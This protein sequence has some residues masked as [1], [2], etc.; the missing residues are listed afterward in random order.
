MSVSPEVKQLT[1]VKQHRR[2]VRRQMILPIII[3][4]V[5][6][7]LF[8]I[9]LVIPAS[10]LYLAET[11]DQISI[12]SNLM[13]SVFVLCP[14]VLCLWLFFVILVFM[15]V[16]LHKSQGFTAKQMRRVQLASRNLADKTATNADNVSKRSI[17]VTARFAFFN[18]I[19]NIFD[20]PT[21]DDEVDS[22]HQIEES[23]KDD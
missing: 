22:S 23:T 18:R 10:P 7:L 9:A 11:E 5:L 17:G 14:M 6:I 3:V 15:S 2:T 4:G 13:I 21:N 8:L 12:V 19:F 16:G 20:Q 1:S